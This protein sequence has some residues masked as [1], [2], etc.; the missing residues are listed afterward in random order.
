M[1]KYDEPLFSCGTDCA[2]WIENNCDKCIKG[3]KFHEKDQSYG[4]F[5]C[6]AQHDIIGAYLD[7]GK[8]SKR[9]YDISQHDDCPLKKTERK[10]Y[11]RKPKFDNQPKLFEEI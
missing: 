2:W 10:Q 7:D 11:P 1:K 6:K 4:P 3:Q 8:A 9:V 5:Y